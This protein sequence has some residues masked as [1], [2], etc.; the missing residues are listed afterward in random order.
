M[1]DPETP[2]RT[3]P[4]T[5]RTAPPPGEA[6]VLAHRWKAFYCE[7]RAVRALA[8]RFPPV[9]LI[10]GAFQ[11]KESWGRCEEVFL[12]NM[13][14]FTVDPPGW[15]AADPLPETYGVDFLADAICHMLDECGARQV[16]VLARS[17][18]SAIAY[19][20]ARRCPDRIGRM[21]LVGT[22]RAV[23][24]HAQT[25]MLRTPEHLTAGDMETYA[26]TTLDL[27]MTPE[28]LADIP[29]GARVRRLLLRRITNLS[30]AEAH[31]MRT[32]TLR[33]PTHQALDTSRPPRAPVLTVAGEYDSFTTP[34]LCRRMAAACADSWHAEIRDADHMLIL[35]RTAEVADLITRFLGGE[36]LHGLPYCRSVEQVSPSIAPAREPICAT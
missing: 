30:E 6:L 33:L 36:P 5:A 31:Q 12:G 28:R 11:R 23:P 29:N 24:D 17:Y 2:V 21:V 7:S 32:N 13:D 18:G 1:I 25:A 34:E 26:H 27:L 14:V 4:L 15:G 20:M 16:N 35:E 10:G 3:P 22:M 8:P 9:L 19:E